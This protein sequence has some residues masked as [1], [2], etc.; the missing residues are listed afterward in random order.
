M[1]PEEKP[2]VGFTPKEIKAFKIHA[3]VVAA[4]TALIFVLAP[5]GVGP[6]VGMVFALVVLPLPPL[7]IYL[8]R[9]RR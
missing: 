7:V 3:V 9:R 8:R 1:N 4:L 2:R 6:A 5:K